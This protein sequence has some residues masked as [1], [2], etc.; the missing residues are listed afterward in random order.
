MN[1]DRA[2]GR[3]TQHGRRQDQPVS[4]DDGDIVYTI[5]T[6]AAVKTPQGTV[7]PVGGTNNEA[8][9]SERRAVL[10]RKTSGGTDSPQGSR[11]V[12]RVLTASQATDNNNGRTNAKSIA[13]AIDRAGVPIVKPAGGH[14]VYID[15]AAFF[16]RIP[17]RP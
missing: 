7:M 11:F 17:A 13:D 5:V 2:E 12:E 8:E 4:G 6:A 1:V 15:A 3:C 9:R 16:P 14:A 10:W